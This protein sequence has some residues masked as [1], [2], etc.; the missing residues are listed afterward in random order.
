MFFET[1]EQLALLTKDELRALQAKA[2]GLT[3]EDAAVQ[4]DIPVTTFTS[5]LKA[6]YGKLGYSSESNATDDISNK[7]CR[8]VCATLRAG[9]IQGPYVGTVPPTFTKKE[10]A[11]LE[12]LQYGFSTALIAH[13]LR[14]AEGTVRSRLNTITNKCGT[15]MRTQIAAIAVIHHLI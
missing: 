4:L 11:V 5:R 1:P 6:A 14:L 3:D 12:L 10:L 2:C 13:R 9:M 8:A 15:G 7:A